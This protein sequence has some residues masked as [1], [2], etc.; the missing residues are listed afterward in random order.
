M[1]K[2]ASTV[3]KRDLIAFLHSLMNCRF[4]HIIICFGIFFSLS[5]PLFKRFHH[6]WK[7]SK[8]SQTP[9]QIQKVCESIYYCF[10][11]P[12][13][14]YVLIYIVRATSSALAIFLRLFFVFAL[15]FLFR[16]KI[17]QSNLLASFLTN[18]NIT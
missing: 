18:V 6:I 8:K 12:F 14:G 4:P 10:A 13:V 1:T 5:E 11:T 2:M 3:L 17:S 16:G 15:F 7:R 9:Q